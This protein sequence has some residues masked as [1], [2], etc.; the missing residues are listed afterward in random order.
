MSSETNQEGDG[1]SISA[2]LMLSVPSEGFEET[3]DELRDLGSEVTTDTVEGEDVTEEFVDLEVRER[4][5]LA[6]EASLVELYDQSQ[7][8]DDTLAVQRE[9][10]NIRGQI[11][12]VQGRLEYLEQRTDFSQIS[13][14]I[15]PAAGT[16]EGRPA[17]DPAGVAAGAWD[18][19]L[20]FLQALATAVISIIAFGWWLIPLLILG[21]VLW[22]R[23]RNQ[24]GS[25]TTDSSEAP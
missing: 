21:L 25:S 13:L 12:R 2:D 5:L 3:L 14:S 7:S 22:R 9:L 11:E 20:R 15:Q 10:T 6:A 18:A 24:K 23:R 1:G 19:S 17:W 8:V 16:A 4:N